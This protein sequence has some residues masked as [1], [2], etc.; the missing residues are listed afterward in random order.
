MRINEIRIINYKN[1]KDATMKLEANRNGYNKYLYHD[2]T[3]QD[4]ILTPNL[5]AL[6]GPNAAGKSVFLD[7]LSFASSVVN[8]L[9]MDRVLSKISESLSVSAGL[10]NATHAENKEKAM[11]IYDNN[12]QKVREI[13]SEIISEIYHSI[14]MDSE[15]VVTIDIKTNLG[16]I[17][18]KVSKEKVVIDKGELGLRVGKL[19][20][21]QFYLL[22]SNMFNFEGTSPLNV[23]LNDIDQGIALDLV[24]L[25]DP[26]IVSI[27]Q[28]VDKRISFVNKNSKTIFPEELSTGTKLF[29]HTAIG[30]I[31]I[32][33]KN[34]DIV[35]VDE[36]DTFMHTEL[37]KN[38]ITLMSKLAQK[39]ETMFIFSSHN[40]SVLYGSVRYSQVF[41][42][43]DGVV[44]KLSSK[45]KPNQSVVKQ[46]ENGKIS[47]YVGK[48]YSY[49]V[50]EEVVDSIE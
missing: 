46:Y 16:D 49:D 14:C 35:M 27:H 21:R 44:E 22:E 34:Q 45:L 8:D 38:L 33:Q 10:E 29:L 26:S 5:V 15:E 1:I 24:K 42:I 7:A 48:A 36:I 19:S 43:N 40:M 30:I 20:K 31:K 47:R 9:V 13:E 6:I 11:L 18:I 32:S 23:I 50:I 2:F 17:S 4:G 3:L 39:Y 28:H 12:P 25:A 37:A 41:E